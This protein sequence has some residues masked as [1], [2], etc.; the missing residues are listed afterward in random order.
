[1]CNKCHKTFCICLGALNTDIVVRSYTLKLERALGLL[2]LPS[3][4]V[5]KIVDILWKFNQWE[6]FKDVEDI[7]ITISKA[8]YLA[9]KHA[10]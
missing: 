9:W 3:K 1:M 7:A 4:D 8:L 5:D 10:I 6:N 2:N